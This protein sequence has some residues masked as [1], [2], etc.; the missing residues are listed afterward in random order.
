MKIAVYTQSGEKK[1]AKEIK[2]A[3]LDEPIN[4]ALIHEAIVAQLASRR[5][6]SAK[7]KTRGEVSGGGKKPYRQKGTGRA[8]TGSTRNPIWT[9]GGI[10]FGPTGEQNF[11]RDMPKK[12]KRLAIVSALSS[13]KN[14]IINIESIT[15]DKTKDFAKLVEKIAGE[16]K[17]LI[18]FPGLTEK[19]VLPT[20][21]LK[22]IKVC[23]YRNL[24]VYDILNAEKLVFVG[25]SLN[26]ASEYLGR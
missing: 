2:L 25:D 14:E 11:L 4:P 3:F 19:N 16:A 26:K 6:A 8:R 5:L 18:I 1:E 22:N 15:V 24:N 9:G 10:T 7:V 17:S 23:D 21:N 13:K 20:R 12:K